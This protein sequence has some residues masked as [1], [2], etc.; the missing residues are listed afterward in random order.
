[1]F[2]SRFPFSGQ[3]EYRD[4]GPA[5]LKMIVNYFGKKI[6]YDY[7]KKI[8]PTDNKGV[9]LL[10]LNDAAIS[11]GFNT[12]MIGIG[13]SWLHTKIA[14]PCI[15]WGE[16]H[17]VVIYKVE[18]NYVFVAD[19]QVG[20]LKLTRENF[21]SRFS[22]EDN[23]GRRCFA[24][25]LE[26][27]PE[28][29]AGSFDSVSDI[30]I[31]LRTVFG[32]YFRVHKKLFISLIITL[33]FASLI[34]LI[35]PFTIQ[36]T[37]DNGIKNSDLRFVLLV[38]LAQL[39][40]ILGRTS[41]D[42]IRSWTILYVNSKINISILSDFITKLI[43]L[44]ITFY[45]KRNTGDVMQRLNDCQR[46]TS[47]LANSSFQ[48]FFNLITVSVL[49]V[50]VLL[51]SRI[52]FYIFLFS[53]ILYLSWIIFYLRNRRKMDKRRFHESSEIHA[54]QLELV[55]GIL[56]IKIFDRD[57]QKS[58]NWKSKQIKLFN[59]NIQLFSIE[60]YLTIGTTIINELK[61]LVIILWVSKEVI[62]G[63]ISLGMMLAISQIIG[64]AN[65]PLYQLVDLFRQLQDARL[66]AR[67]LND[68]MV[69]PEEDEDDSIEL[70]ETV[71]DDNLKDLVLN[72]V[73][74]RYNQEA[75]MWVLNKIRLTIPHGGVTSIVG[76]S[77]SGKSTLIKLLLKIYRYSSGSI[78]VGAISLQSIRTSTW[79]GHCGAV[80]QEGFI[81]SD[82]IVGNIAFKQKLDDYTVI[83]DILRTVNMLE[84][85]ET[86]PLGIHTRIGRDGQGLSQGQKQ[87]IL[88]ARA[89]YRNPTYLFLD[90]ATSA[91]DA[92]NEAEIITNL[93]KIKS[94][95]TLVT[96]AHRLSTVKNSDQIVVLDKGSIVEIGKH[97][98]LVDRR[99]YYYNLIKNQLELN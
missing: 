19:P 72:D 6:S 32:K 42:L 75:D 60:Q 22:L 56:D 82:T 21:R 87:R 28:F 23:S 33:L 84:F 1:V 41:I 88:I 46:I 80:L 3:T 81:F 50:V 18:R 67:R 12:K 51:Y 8:C 24:L 5:C 35:I 74:F 95:R 40:L 59:T 13:F 25:I 85:V 78:H 10:K 34:T 26:P 86:L 73:F 71:P 17:F 27:H 93:N 70:L 76:S 20:L 45:D 44:P 31:S 38:L 99:G 37:V 11:L 43:K 68:V 91:L 52:T 9:S 66:S 15:F 83:E 14:L 55:E 96:V 39:M 58:A 64:Q 61:N 47:F 92:I 29:Y 98:D 4:C 79:Q 63:S 57:A 48:I 65:L 2:K 54:A 30:K 16:Q 77:G 62:E 94:G 49:G 97:Q 53:S 69:L 89:L 7:L 36:L 90:E